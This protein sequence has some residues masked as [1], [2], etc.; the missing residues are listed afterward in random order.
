MHWKECTMSN[1][2]KSTDKFP[3]KMV[4]PDGTVFTAYGVSKASPPITPLSGRG[5]SPAPRPA[6][7]T[8]KPAVPVDWSFWP[9]S[10]RVKRDEAIAL[11]LGLDPHSLYSN[12]D[13]HINPEFCPDNATA[14]LFLKRMA[15]LAA[16]DSRTNILLSEFSAWAISVGMTPMP[17]KFVAL[18]HAQ[19][20]QQPQSTANDQ[21]SCN[22]VEQSRNGTIIAWDYWRG[23]KQITPQQAAELA[24]CV[25]PDKGQ[26]TK[27]LSIRIQRLA[28]SLAEHS[29]TWT[30]SVLV[31][32]L[33]ED[34]PF[35]MKQVVASGN[36][37]APAK[38]GAG[39]AMHT[40]HKKGA[41][42]TVDDLQE[43]LA[44]SKSMTQ[45]QLAQFHGIERQR[46]STLLAQAKDQFGTR[47]STDLSRN[48][49]SK[50]IQFS[51]KK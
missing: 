14:I 21:D 50:L 45:E 46:I 27:E 19:A 13:G 22:M 2:K 51:N 47:S 17:D 5:I 44:D 18:A 23:R 29:P 3:R 9:A 7:T 43:L 32:H 41:K 49:L 16:C 24:H 40:P 38:A 30:L 37:I 26:K 36:N 10:R 33:G 39:D 4:L 6:P 31:E 35:N 8:H 42:W 48:P 12:T 20:R 15:Q 34:A 1:D 25:E 28:E 11:S